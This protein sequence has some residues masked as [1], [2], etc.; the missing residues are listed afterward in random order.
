MT[1]FTPPLLGHIWTFSRTI[2]YGR[3]E[4]CGALEGLP[5]AI[6][7]V[8]GKAP[9]CRD[10]GTR[11]SRRSAKRH[12]GA[13]QRAAHGIEAL[14]E[15][16]SPQRKKTLGKDHSLPRARLSVKPAHGKGLTW[17]LPSAFADSPPFGSW[18]TRPLPRAI[19][20]SQQRFFLFL[21]PNFF[22][23]P[24][25]LFESTC[26]NLAQFSIFWLYF[27]SLFN[28]IAFFK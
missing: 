18:Q 1:Q 20:G 5:S 16:P 17:Y 24:Y 23:S 3:A 9:L 21:P 7:R 12:L 25:T 26:Y 19:F 27:I 13:R 8:L 14:R 15:A 4:L 11:R 2:H 10:P 22:V 6:C 28:L